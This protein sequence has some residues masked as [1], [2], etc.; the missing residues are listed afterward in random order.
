RIERFRRALWRLGDG[1]EVA[2]KLRKRGNRSKINRLGR[3][4]S[5][6]FERLTTVD[7]L[8]AAFETI[9]AQYDFRQGAVFGVCPFQSDR[10]KLA[11]HLRLMRIPG[12][13]HATVLKAGDRLLAAHLGVAD[14]GI[15]Y[16]GFLTYSPFEAQLS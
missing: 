5:L 14:R 11:F 4:G 15:V 1:R 2:A 10:L 8:K 12:L 9:I 3:F 7:E 13:L 16:G 6:R